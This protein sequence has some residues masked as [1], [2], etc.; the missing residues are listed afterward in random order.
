M[1]PDSLPRFPVREWLQFLTGLRR[2][3]VTETMEQSEKWLSQAY[4]AAQHDRGARRMLTNYAAVVTAWRFLCEFAGIAPGTGNFLHD[5]R[6]EMNSHIRDTAGDREPYVWIL[7][8]IASEL[9]AG[10]FRH[11]WKIDAVDDQAVLLIRPKDIIGHIS[12]SM[13]LREQ[14]N[15]L[16]VKTAS[17]LAKQLQQAGLVVKSG[18]D[19]I[20]RGRRTG[21]MYALSLKGMSELGISLSIDDTQADHMVAMGQLDM[22]EEA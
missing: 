16:P 19:K 8:L 12:T 13:R 5:L 14:W 20:I 10:E 17:V 6:A 18:L 21:H 4:R 11:P 15:G 2:E 1:P 7:E 3:R 9:D 22:A